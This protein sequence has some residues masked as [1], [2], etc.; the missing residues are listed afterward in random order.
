M[1]NA[2]TFSDLIPVSI[3]DIAGVVYATQLTYDLYTNDL[4]YMSIVGY[5]T[6]IDKVNDILVKSREAVGIRAR[7]SYCS[8]SRGAQYIMDT[9]KN[10]NSDLVHANIYI[11]DYHKMD[12]NSEEFTVYMY[13]YENDPFKIDKLKD[14]LYDKLYKYSSVPMIPE[15]KEYIYDRLNE[16]RYIRLAR[17]LL[18]DGNREVEVYKYVGNQEQLKTFISEGLSSGRIS[19]AGSNEPSALLEDI[20]GLNDYL[21]IFGSLLADKIQ[22]KFRPKFIPGTDNYTRYLN[23]IDDYIH[24]KGVELYEAQLAVIQSTVNNFNINKYGIIVGEMGCGKTLQA[25]ASCYVHNANKY[26]G[27]NSLVMAPSHLVEKWKSEMENYI[28]NAKGYIIHNLDELLALENKLRDRNRVENMYVIMSKEIAKLGFDVRPAAIWSKSKQCFV[29]PECGQPLF[30]IENQEQ[31]YSRRKI[32][33]KI[34]L[35]ELDFLK[36]YAHNQIC[37]NEIKYWDKKTHSYKTKKCGAKLWTALNRDDQTHGWL[38]LGEAGW[39]R[40]EFI[41]QETEK[42]MA[43]DKLDKKETTLFNKLFD[44]Y[45]YYQNNG[46]F[47]ITY[48]GP[49]KYP[50]AQ[51]IY[52]RMNGLFDYFIADEMHQLMSNSL[53]GHAAHILMKAAKHC[54]LLTGTLLNG[55]ASNIFYTLFRVCPNIMVQEGFRYEDEMEFARLFGVTSR[56]STFEVSRGRSGNR[57]GSTREKELPGI[58]PLIFTK[59]LLNLTAFIALDSMTEGLPDYEEIPVG[60]EMDASTAAGYQQI[61]DFFS[62]RVG[63]RQGQTKKIMGSMIKLMTQ[64]PDAP[65]CKRWI[66]NPDTNEVEYESVPLEKTIRNKEQRLLEIIQNKIANGEKVLVYYNTIN[67]TDLGD[68]LT[69]YL[70]SEDIKAFELKASVKAEKRMEFITK[71]VNKGAQVMITNPSLVETGLDLLDFTTIIFFQIGYNLSTM[72][73]ASRRSW[74]LSQTKDIQV[75]FFYYY[76]TIQEQ[77]LALM[78]TKL[79]AAQTIEGNF[80]EEGLKAMSNNEDMLTQI[81]NNVVND[82]KQVVD[83]EAFKSSKYVKEQ[84]NTIREHEKTIKQIEC[85]M[86][87]DGKRCV[88]NVDDTPFDRPHRFIDVSKLKNPIE[89]FL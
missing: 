29:C 68:H 28:P 13:V 11:K 16:S 8:K 10:E 17:T 59:F 57:V 38:K 76:G 81:A 86:N 34:K 83:M 32:K 51:Y 35:T 61:K 22:N 26:K 84:S 72:R 63:G 52:E 77:A 33:V 14:L 20:H 50:V 2:N 18:M 7:G 79:Q 46:H 42:L 27:F 19:I 6:I 60:I 67:T 24:H 80:S 49:K 39:I 64:Y 5:K 37:E 43:K 48:K 47:N 25:G 23:N 78:A 31:P 69:A 40:E 1:S 66:T 56:E 87:A 54:L 73:Q 65:H 30:K 12:V 55:Y 70:C 4:I 41:E 15:W 3:G 21:S 82:I 36:Q 44:Q 58:S 71:E 85:N 9:R 53:Q 62:Q 74:R 89:L 45:E 88:F 75:Y